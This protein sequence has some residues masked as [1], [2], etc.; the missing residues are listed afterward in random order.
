MLGLRIGRIPLLDGLAI[1]NGFAGIDGETGVE[2]FARA[3]YPL[4]GDLQ[5]GPAKLSEAPERGRLHEQ[6]CLPGDD[7]A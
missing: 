2:S 3:P 5:I 1:I 7:G 4:A 6:R